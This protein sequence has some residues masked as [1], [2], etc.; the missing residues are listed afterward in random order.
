MYCIVLIRGLIE[1]GPGYPF[2]IILSTSLDTHSRYQ[3][4]AFR[5]TGPRHKLPSVCNKRSCRNDFD[6]HSPR[7]WVLIKALV[8]SSIVLHETRFGAKKSRCDHLWALLEPST[9]PRSGRQLI[10]HLQ[11]GWQRAESARIEAT[12]T[13]IAANKSHSE[14]RAVFELQSSFELRASESLPPPIL[15]SNSTIFLKLYLDAWSSAV[16]PSSSFTLIS[17][18]LSSKK[19]TPPS[20]FM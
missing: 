13:V 11:R 14:L 17:A 7:L 20:L 8:N 1:I 5:P 3:Q 2:R 19:R 16:I 15:S 4:L 10:K 6:T 18:P 9:T 12:Q